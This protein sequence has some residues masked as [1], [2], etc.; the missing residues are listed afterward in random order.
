MGI[1]RCY[2]SFVAVLWC[3]MQ[4][5]TAQALDHLPTDINPKA[6]IEDDAIALTLDALLNKPRFTARRI[7]VTYLPGAWTEVSPR[8]LSLVSSV[9]ESLRLHDLESPR[10]GQCQSAVQLEVWPPQACN[11]PD[12]GVADESTCE[13]VYIAA[14]TEADAKN[15]ALVV[16]LP[17]A[18]GFGSLYTA[19]D[20]K[21][22]KLALF[23]DRDCVP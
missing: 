21:V 6:T 10:D 3:F 19:T 17:D 11:A 16:F 14:T 5:N 20:R 8:R 15:F 2:L 12:C 23:G 22:L 9:L 18:T 7:C 4:M 1:R 13:P